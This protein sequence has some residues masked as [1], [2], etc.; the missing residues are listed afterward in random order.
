MTLVRSPAYP[1]FRRHID[2]KVPPCYI[3]LMNKQ[4]KIT[5]LSE[6]KE[7]NEL[8]NSAEKRIKELKA[9]IK[10]EIEAGKYGDYVLTYEEREVKEFTVAA[11]VDTILKVS[12][13]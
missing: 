11:R 13:I 3:V 1:I 7:L 12:K 9:Q 6:F 8:K 4:D 5:V 2:G 10:A